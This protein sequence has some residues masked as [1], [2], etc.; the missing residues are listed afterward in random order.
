MLRIEASSWSSR[1]CRIVVAITAATLA[2][3]GGVRGQEPTFQPRCGAG[4]HADEGTGVI[5]LPQG[6]LFCPLVAD[7][8]AA[9]TYAS[10]VRGDFAT[11][12]DAQ[13][14]DDTDI[15]SVGLGDTFGLLRLA[16]SRAGDGLQV[17]IEGAIF[18]QFNLDTPSFDLI[19]ADYLVG[20]PVTFRVRGNTARLRVYHQS[21]HLGDEFLLASQPER[22]NLS[23]ESIELIVSRE[24]GPARVYAG[25]ENFFRRRPADLAAKLLHGG[26][27]YRPAGGQNRIVAALD[28]KLVDDDGWQ[29]GWSARAG[30][31]IARIPSPG[32]PARVLSILGQFYDGPAPYGQFYRDDI[33]FFGLGLHFSL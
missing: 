24:A 31:E 25:G 29:A 12:A 7:P 27:E 21:S 32:H 16:A 15:G 11:L 23:F 18:A 26:V 1:S 22:V 33:R 13:P 14:G 3:P 20:L 28:I 4:I 19:N 6:T 2:Y 9:H 5:L 17:D 10:Y 30:I 8:K